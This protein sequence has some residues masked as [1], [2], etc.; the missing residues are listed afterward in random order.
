[1]DSEEKKIDKEEMLR[2][3]K[4]IWIPKEI[5]FDDRKF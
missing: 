5:W 1:M 2:N 4:G 3:F